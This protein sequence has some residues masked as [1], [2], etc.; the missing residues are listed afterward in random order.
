[1]SHACNEVCECKVRLD[2]AIDLLALSSERL[3]DVIFSGSE[4][5]V[6]SAHSSMRFARMRFLEALAECREQL[7]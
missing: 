2:V 4:E 6:K 3:K 1:M 7:A 5:A